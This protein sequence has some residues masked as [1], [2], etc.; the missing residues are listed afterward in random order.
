MDREQYELFQRELVNAEVVQMKEFEKEILFSGC[1]PIESM[2]MKGHDTMRFGPLKPVGLVNPAT[3]K[4]PWAVVQLRQD[5]SDATL[6]N[7][8]GFQTHLKWPEQKRVFGLIPGL[9]NAEFARYGVMH[10]NTF[11][12]SPGILDNTYCMKENPRVYFAGQITGVE[13]YIESASSGM[14]AGINAAHKVLGREPV[15]F[16]TSTASGALAGYVSNTTVRDFQP[17]NV[18]FG[19]MDLPDVKIRNKAQKNI[20]ISN[21]AI[22]QISQINQIFGNI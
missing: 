9:E 21:R 1:M 19:I 7:I 16:P 6:F 13:G 15:I 20:E 10:R 22:S 14:V 17:M 3:G 8:V 12:K 2:A 18:N 5:N 11:I 4:E